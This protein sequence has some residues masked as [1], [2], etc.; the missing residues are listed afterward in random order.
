MITLSANFPIT[1]AAGVVNAA[2]FSAAGIGVAPGLIVTIFGAGL[3]PDTPA[4]AKLNS[5]GFIDT[6][7]GETRVL[8]D[9]VAS[10]MVATSRGQ[11]SAIVPYAVAG[12]IS[13]QLQVEYQG[14]Q[15][16]AIPVPVVATAPGV[17]TANASGAGQAAALNEDNSLNSAVNA[18]ARGSILTLF[19]TG[20]GQ[21]MPTGVDGKLA[22]TPL[23]KPAA[24]ATVTIGGADAEIVYVGGAPGLTAGL[25]Q[26]NV[27]VP[28]NAPV[29]AATPLLVKIGGTNS[30]AGVTVAI[31]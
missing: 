23:P 20:E 14:K 19:A 15:S 13:T 4:T 28:S 5:Q 26:I 17:F 18:I 24:S 21:T 6:N 11:I 7:L 30:Q 16:T 8:F 25:L 27:R 9:G 22:A 3:G 12:K 2:S 10:P 1:T 29:G 31:R